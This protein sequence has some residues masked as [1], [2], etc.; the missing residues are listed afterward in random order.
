MKKKPAPK[1]VPTLAQKMSSI[2]RNPRACQTLKISFRVESHLQRWLRDY[3]SQQLV[4]GQPIG[5]TTAINEALEM[6]K[7]RDEKR[8]REALAS[9]SRQASDVPQ[10]PRK[11]AAKK[12]GK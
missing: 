1:P 12:R 6:M 8:H 10:R 3:A 2:G 5:M 4:S 7:D 11:A 9:L